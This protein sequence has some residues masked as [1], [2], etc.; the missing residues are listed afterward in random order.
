MGELNYIKYFVSFYFQ[1]HNGRTGYSNTD[2][3][4]DDRIADIKDI[5]NIQEL[6]KETFGYSAVTVLNFILLGE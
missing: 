4:T 3:T 2:L 1:D 5:K 6:Y